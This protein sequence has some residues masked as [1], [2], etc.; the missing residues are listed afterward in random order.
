MRLCF[1]SVEETTLSIVIVPELLPTVR[2]ISPCSHLSP[3]PNR[4]PT[5][6]S[7]SSRPS[8]NTFAT[9]TCPISYFYELPPL[10]QSKILAR[11]QE[12]KHGEGWIE[13]ARRSLERV[14]N[15]M[16]LADELQSA[17]EKENA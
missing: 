7:L 10:E 1:T 5:I 15:R 12:L 14:P 13:D 2:V 9:I 17:L 16:P 6:L 4:S 8:P 11:A 3:S